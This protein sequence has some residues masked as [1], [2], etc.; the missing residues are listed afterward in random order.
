[1]IIID[2]LPDAISTDCSK[3]TDKQKESSEKVMHFIIDH[4]PEDWERLEQKYDTSGNYRTDYLNTK[5]NDHNHNT[6]K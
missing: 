5:E 6:S 3:C 1:M 4:R 2:T